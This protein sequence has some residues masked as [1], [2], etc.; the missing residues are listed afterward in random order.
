MAAHVSA[1]DQAQEQDA[2][3]VEHRSVISVVTDEVLADVAAKEDSEN[4]DGSHTQSV[5]NLDR[6]KLS[7]RNAKFLKSYEVELRQTHS[8]VGTGVWSRSRKVFQFS[9]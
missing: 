5:N 1:E 7:V 6:V 3:P 2:D 8:E 9:V 4:E